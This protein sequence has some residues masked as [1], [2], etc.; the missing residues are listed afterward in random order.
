MKRIIRIVAVFLCLTLL[1]GCTSIPALLS[2]LDIPDKTE[3]ETISTFSEIAYVRPDMD[4]ISAQYETT[5]AMHADSSKSELLDALQTCWEQY[6]DFYTMS[7]VAEIRSYID[8]TDTYYADEAAFCTDAQ[9][10][11]DQLFE[12][13]QIASANCD[14]AEE[15]EEGFWGDGLISTYGYADDGID[16]EGDHTDHYEG[17][18]TDEYVAL[19]Q[20]ESR[21]LTVYRN[22]LSDPTVLY[23]G[24]EA[25]YRELCSDES[26]SDEEYNEVNMAYY[27]KYSEILGEIYIDLVDVRQQIA[28]YLGY[29]SYEAYA[30][31]WV[32]GR[33][34]TPAQA[35][36]LLEDIRT[37]LAPLYRRA[38][39]EGLW[40]E[41]EYAEVDEQ[42]IFRKVQIVA[43][44][45]GGEIAESFGCLTQH[46][47]YDISISD[48]KM[49]MS[50]Q[51]YLDSYDVP[52]V[53]VKTYGYD[54]D[55]L[56]FAHEFGHFV[57]SYVNYNG[58]YSLELSEVFSQ[59][60]EY[61]LLCT[62]PEEQLGDLTAIK[63]LDTLD[64]YTQQGSFAQFEREVYAIPAEE[65]TVEKLNELSLQNA[66]DYGYAEE[67]MEDYY[68]ES[69]IDIGHFFEY[70]FY[71]VSYC[72]SN[73]AAFQIYQ[74]ELEQSGAGL[75]QFN[76]LLP[77]DNDGFLDTL[78]AQSD[79]ES[80]FA[81]G[82]MEKT[83]QTVQE[84]LWG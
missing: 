62:L 74:L 5:V 56:S 13:L 17:T 24:V 76:S 63:L 1:C 3:K 83:A 15:L 51:T 64:T 52:F 84:F 8:M 50:Y 16:D 31:D 73:D 30:Y 79:L 46:E 14:L 32:Y 38:N 55:A 21:L 61:L 48:K 28:A 4:A 68:A 20:E 7:T 37:W 12:Q 11:M 71:V 80:P 41:V 18:Y 43:Q 77:R 25:S 75:A 57:D 42:D 36:K 67:D 60:M 59:S 9:P 2:K 70:P 65:L 81:A 53:L 44:K 82:R 69:W 78:K 26:L 27:D 29:D 47:L 40:D 72:V 45:L 33:D 58:T 22:E 39:E 19:L 34:Y 23:K 49:E 54:D 6:L 66:E 35:D 10:Q